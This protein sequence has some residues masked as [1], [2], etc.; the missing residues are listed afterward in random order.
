[1]ELQSKPVSIARIMSA[2]S[3]LFHRAVVSAGARLVHKWCTRGRQGMPEPGRRLIRGCRASGWFSL[4]CASG[5]VRRLA[6]LT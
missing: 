1:M 6:V 2:M 4:V 5:S 3:D